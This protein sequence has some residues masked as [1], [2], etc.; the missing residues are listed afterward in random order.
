MSVEISNRPNLTIITLSGHLDAETSGYCEA[1]LVEM[2]VQSLVP[3]VVDLS[4]VTYASSEGLR[5]F[6]VMAKKAKENNLPIVF[7]NP[8]PFV[9]EVLEVTMFIK[10][11][12]L[13][14]S[15]QEAIAKVT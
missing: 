6:M 2:I 9:R 12:D 15:V 7:A 3:L 14:D 13:V 5:L 1:E 8:T 4:N 11:I 10:I